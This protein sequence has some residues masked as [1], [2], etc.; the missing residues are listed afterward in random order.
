MSPGAA[1][2]GHV[3]GDRGARHTGDRAYF[4]QQLPFEFFQAIVGNIGFFKSDERER[5]SFLPHAGIEAR[6]IIEA[7]NEKQSAHQQYQRD[8]DLRHHHRALEGETFAAGRLTAASALH[9]GHR[10]RAGSAEGRDHAEDDA[11]QS[12]AT[13]A[14]NRS[15]RQSRSGGERRRRSLR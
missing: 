13:K 11:G 3:R 12:V 1:D 4:L 8:R 6:Q 14:A 2:Q 9:R 7:A 15:T 5:N 10:I